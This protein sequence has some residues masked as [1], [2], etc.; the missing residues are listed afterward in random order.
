[1]HY[2][3]SP[4]VRCLY[5]TEY[6]NLE[7]IHPNPTGKQSFFAKFLSSLIFVFK[8]KSKNRASEYQTFSQQKH[9][10]KKLLVIH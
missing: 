5:T 2:P 6:T 7:H 1:M 9:S 3:E 4:K 8:L 10:V